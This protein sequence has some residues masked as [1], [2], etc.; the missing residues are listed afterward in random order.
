MDSAKRSECFN[1][2]TEWYNFGE[3]LES[4][5]AATVAGT[6]NVTNKAVVSSDNVTNEAVVSSNNVTNEAIMSSDNAIKE[7][8]LKLKLRTWSSEAVNSHAYFLINI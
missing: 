8:F 1:W 6:K 7:Q 5:K 3:L 4:K 2:S